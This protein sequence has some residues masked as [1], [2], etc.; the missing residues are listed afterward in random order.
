MSRFS[1]F[2]S[3]ATE[4]NAP[5]AADFY[6]LRRR[7]QAPKAQALGSRPSVPSLQD[8]AGVDVLLGAF[9]ELERNGGPAPGLD[10]LTFRDFGPGERAELARGLSAALRTGTYRPYRGRRLGIPKPGTA[11]RRVLTIRNIADRVVA[12]ALHR[13][14]TPFWET[15]FL[16]N[17]LG[18]RPGR[19]V[20]HLLARLER[21]MTRTGRWVLA[22]DDIYRA[23][24]HVVID[25]VLDGHRTL[26]P[27]EGL[28]HTVEAVLRGHAGPH[29]TL[30][31]DQGCPYSPTA[32]NVAL[33]FAHDLPAQQG[34]L[35]PW[36]RYADNLVYL[37]RD[38]SEG[39]QALAM[40]RDLLAKA[41]FS[42]KGKDAGPT[43]L[44]AGQPVPFLGFRLRHHK[45]QV[46]YD[47]DPEAWEG[48]EQDLG[49]AHEAKDPPEIA[50][51]VIRG[52][53]TA[54]GP[55][56]AG[57]R[58]VHVQKV[59]TISTRSGFPKVVGSREA[60]IWWKSSWKNWCAFREKVYGES[61]YEG[62]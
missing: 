7:R 15:V 60:G 48:L 46:V 62:T 4:R 35:P 57:I 40:A 13:A 44:R 30:G 34:H 50:R 39:T 42:L 61:G 19:G 11:D 23:F 24:D 8:V 32:L 37:C 52:W 9:A 18:F 25:A 54:N 20:W 41:S 2:R 58:T 53:I 59:L 12:A 56:F 29:H 17:N 10:G 45:E 49:K 6:Q 38:V 14:L 51:A 16:P 36:Y 43:D 31:I 5:A 55:A 3:P 27:D 26:L 28:I 22:T 1:T 33:H 47:L 21:T